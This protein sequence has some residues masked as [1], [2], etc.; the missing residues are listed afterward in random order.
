MQ[1]L[2]ALPQIA[3]L[4]TLLL[5]HIPAHPQSKDVSFRLCPPKVPRTDLTQD[6]TRTARPKLVKRG[7]Q[8]FQVFTNKKT[9]RELFRVPVG[10]EEAKYW[11][12]GVMQEADFNGD[13]IPD[14]CWHGGDDTSQENLLVLSSPSG[15]RKVDIYESLQREWKRRFPSDP[16]EELSEAI[17]ADISEMKVVRRSGTVFLEALVSYQDTNKDKVEDMKT[18]THRLRV[19]QSRFAY[20]K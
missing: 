19:P 18:Y 11:V 10:N 5:P 12:Y 17:T 2:R 20:M 8:F 14:F 15:Y 3:F 9:G 13:G 16:L 1:A 7:K 6:E 4:V